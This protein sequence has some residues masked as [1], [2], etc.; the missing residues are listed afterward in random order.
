MEENVMKTRIALAIC[1]LLVLFPIV[2]YGEVWNLVNDFSGTQNPNGAWSFG[3]RQTPD[4]PIILYTDNGDDPVCPGFGFEGWWYNIDPN[5]H[6]NPNDYPVECIGVIRPAH[7]AWFHPGPA[8]QSV[9]RWTA[10]EDME[11]QLVAHFTILDIGS[12]IVRIYHN[13]S[14]LF[15]ATLD[16][17]GQGAD[18]TTTLNVSTGDVIDTT[19]DPISFYY[20]TTHLD[21]VLTGEGP[22]A[23][24]ATTWGQVKTLYR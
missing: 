5:V 19:V 1:L 2:S 3:W 9:V 22:T 21:V 7:S 17:L 12:D 23:V 15:S 8:Q 6:L 13:G 11:V 14:E 4:Q 16:G 18:F 20:D 24:R 10:P